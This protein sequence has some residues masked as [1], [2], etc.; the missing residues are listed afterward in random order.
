VDAIVAG[1]A[2]ASEL[3]LRAHVLVQ[4]ERFG[5]L[6]ASLNAWASVAQPT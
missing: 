1:D 3:A 2:D 6:M 4:G 5:D